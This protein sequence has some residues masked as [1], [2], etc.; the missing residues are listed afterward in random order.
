MGH[1]DR[2]RLMFFADRLTL[3]KPRRSSEGYMGVHA[4]GARSGTYQYLGREIDPDG[5]HFAADQVVNVYRAPEQVFDPRA[6]GSF[7]AKPI[8]DDHPTKPVTAANWRDL[9]GGTIMGAV[10]EGEYIGFDLAFLDAAVI[11]SV[12]S[13]KRELSCG[14]ASEIIIE[15]GTAPDGTPY[16]ARQV[17]I[18]GNHIAIVD[19]GRAGGTCRIGDAAI[20]EPMPSD[21][22]R[23]QL[24][25]GQT[26]RDSERNNK[27][28]PTNAER[29][30]GEIQMPHT[31]II[32][33]LQ[34][35][36][37]SDEAKAAIDKLQGQVKA[38]TNDK[39]ALETKVG[40]H[41]ATIATRDG[42]ITALNAKLKDAEIGPEKL[43]Q[44]V[45]D[46]A[47]LVGKAKA[48][49]P[50]IVTDGKTDAE[51]R[52]AVVTAKLGDAA[53]TDDNGIAGAFAALTADA[54]VA[55]PVT[56]AIGSKITLVADDGANVRNLARAA[57]Y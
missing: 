10:Q 50:A 26:Y 4:K 21:D 9:A 45:A 3:D 13:G 17:A 8:T 1:A 54:Q 35:P 37:V 22:V 39:A 33:G 53:P 47:Q 23:K 32:D 49:D 6:L 27:N 51:I 19:K 55:D 41:A 5:K 11:D 15:D 36:N 40:E 38:L 56:A 30:S 18:R 12:D 42:E 20:C 7:V 57:Q 48:V 16:H 14:Y 2:G 52:K 29:Q 34:V 46:R 25:D 28:G 44:M 24:S 31:L 43:Q